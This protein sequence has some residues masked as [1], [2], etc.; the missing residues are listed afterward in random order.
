ML[1]LGDRSAACLASAGVSPAGWQC[2]CSAGGGKRQDFFLWVL[3][4][5]S[6]QSPVQ[7]DSVR[8]LGLEK[9]R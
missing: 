6:K 9:W 3:Q 8:E 7:G 4:K 1:E 5:R 2:P